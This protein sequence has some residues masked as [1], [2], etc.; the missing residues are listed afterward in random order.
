VFDKVWTSVEG[1]MRDMRRRLDEG[2]R[3]ATR[4]TEEQERIIE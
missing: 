4:S 3:D 1:I 2:L